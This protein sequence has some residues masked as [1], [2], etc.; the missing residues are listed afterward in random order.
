[1]TELQY[2]KYRL[3]KEEIEPIKNFLF[4]CG[5]KYHGKSI[6]HYGM[7]LIKK[8]FNI[9]RKG[10]GATPDTEVTIPSELQERIV[11]VIEQWVDEKQRE[12]DVL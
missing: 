3:L 9:G 10:Y 8:K 1:M 4:W 5:S 7:R 12:L 2:Q 11:E 6:S